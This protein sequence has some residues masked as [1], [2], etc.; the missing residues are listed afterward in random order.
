MVQ[1][2]REKVSCKSLVNYAGSTMRALVELLDSI[3]ITNLVCSYYILNVFLY[4][5]FFMH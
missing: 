2:G 4:L 3:L 1:G 5:F